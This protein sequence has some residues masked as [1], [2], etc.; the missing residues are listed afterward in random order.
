MKLRIVHIIS[1][2]FIVLFLANGLTELM[3]MYKVKLN[4]TTAIAGGME[5]PDDERDEIEPEYKSIFLSDKIAYTFISIAFNL[6]SKKMFPDGAS[7][8]NISLPVFTPPPE[9]S[10]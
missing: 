10:C 4:N 1:F 2:L 7:W 6:D 3:V 5:T 8:N 9:T